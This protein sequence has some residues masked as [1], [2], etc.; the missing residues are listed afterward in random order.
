MFETINEAF[1]VLYRRLLRSVL[2]EFLDDALQTTFAALSCLCKPCRRDPLLKAPRLGLGIFD[3][4]F[5]EGI[6][7]PI[8]IMCSIVH[9]ASARS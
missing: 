2:S 3:V 1:L 9:S 7:R 5:R 8:V 6:I 4:L